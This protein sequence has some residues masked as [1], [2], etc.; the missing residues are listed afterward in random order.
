M[1]Q[2]FS[3][4][5]LEPKVA[6]FIKNHEND[7]QNELLGSSDQPRYNFGE[8]LTMTRLNSAKFQKRQFRTKISDFTENEN[9]D[10]K[11]EF[12]DLS[13]HPTYDF[14]DFPEIGHSNNDFFRENFQKSYIG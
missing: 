11:N 12:P 7:D 14:S 8:K 2:N 4:V 5:I 10:D 1:P 6:I 3:I 9:I 13:D